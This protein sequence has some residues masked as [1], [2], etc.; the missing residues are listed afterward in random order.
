PIALVAQP[1]LIAL[2]GPR[3]MQ[4]VVIS[5][6]YANGTVRDLT[7]FCELGI[8]ATE[9]AETTATGLVTPRKNGN[10]T[11]VARAGSQ[12]CRVP[13]AITDMEKPQPVSFRHEMIAALNV[14]G[15]NQGACH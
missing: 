3:S 15:C 7:P 5:G 12:T 13:V 9:L 4:Q 14:G 1:P 8:E 6:R 11:L 10:T 2:K